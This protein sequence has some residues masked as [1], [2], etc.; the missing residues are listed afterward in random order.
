MNNTYDYTISDY[1][2]SSSLYKTAT[3]NRQIVQ[4]PIAIGGVSILY[5]LPGL[6]WTHFLH[7][8]TLPLALQ[9]LDTAV[10]AAVNASK[11]TLN[12]TANVAAQIFSGTI[13]TWDDPQVLAI[14]QN[15]S[16]A[17][18]HDSTESS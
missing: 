3:A 2:L 15:M 5:N 10:C 7:A 9:T 14:N 6:D 13:K 12:L 17:L 11:W 18:L 1:P 4:L 16:Y 8:S